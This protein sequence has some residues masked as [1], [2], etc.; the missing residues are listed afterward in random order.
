MSPTE[1]IAATYMQAANTSF[2]ASHRTEHPAP[3]KAKRR[4]ERYAAVSDAK[5]G[6]TTE[7]IRFIPTPVFILSLTNER[8]KL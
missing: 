4:S 6:F 1:S 5:R 3:P 7:E 8:I 2:R